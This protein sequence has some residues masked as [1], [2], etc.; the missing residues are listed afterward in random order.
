M[1]K[2]LLIFLL[3]VISLKVFAADSLPKAPFKVLPVTGKISFDGIPDEADWQ[4]MPSLQFYVLD[5]VWG[6]AAAERTEMRFL[7]DENNLY[8]AGKCFY[9]DSS[10]II[11][12]NFRRDGWRGDDWVAVHI[13]S[14][15]DHQTAINFAIYPAGSRY[16]ML[17]SND[18]VELG[19]SPTNPSFNAVWDARSVITKE[20]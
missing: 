9:K 17:I 3:S 14:R 20:G 6:A 5:P 19:N 8:V 4:R 13:D 10:K 1:P 12:R 16:D 7:Y 11:V 15:F 18:A 2:R